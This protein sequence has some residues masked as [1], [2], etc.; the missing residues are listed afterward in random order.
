MLKLDWMPQSFGWL[1]PW[2]Y[3]SHGQAR[4]WEG[5]VFHGGVDTAV[6]WGLGCGLYLGRRGKIGCGK[7]LA[8]PAYELG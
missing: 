8:Y 6:C 3:L 7:L 1:P 4:F 2:W 5:G